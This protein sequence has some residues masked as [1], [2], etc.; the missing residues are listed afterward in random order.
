MD[1]LDLRKGPPS[2]LSAFPVT[3]ASINIYIYLQYHD[4]L[5]NSPLFNFFFLLLKNKTANTTVIARIAITH[6]VATI[7]MAKL[8]FVSSEST[9]NTKIDTFEWPSESADLM[10][11]SAEAKISKLLDSIKSQ[12]R[13]LLLLTDLLFQNVNFVRKRF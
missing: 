13:E 7:V 6:T 10:L 11:V 3:I 9:E 5:A 8:E 12:R 2:H 4:Y 1:I